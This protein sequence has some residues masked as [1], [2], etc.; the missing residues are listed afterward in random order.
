MSQVTLQLVFF[1]G[2]EAID[3]RMPSDSLY[4]SR[5]L[6]DQMSRIAHPPGAEE[7]TLL[8]ALDLFVLLDL[9]GAP[10]PTF[11]NHFDKTLRWFDRLVSAE[12]KLHNL[13]LLASHP[14][15]QS[16]FR[17]DISHGPVE[18]DHIPF[19]QKGVPVLHMIATPFPS[20]WH[21]MED[22]VKNIHYQ[23]IENLTKVLVV[24][25]AEYLGL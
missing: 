6:A 11:V 25:L 3:E 21:T 8:D 24:F 1:D 19:L 23:T 22:T 15:E 13:G 7:T 12:I 20:F 18:D 14:G 2:E 10:N 4:G 16:Y 9:I 17:K 5:H